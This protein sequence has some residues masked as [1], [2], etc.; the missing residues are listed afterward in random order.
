MDC[1]CDYIGLVSDVGISHDKLDLRI[2]T[3]KVLLDTGKEYIG[4]S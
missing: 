3:N 4:E 1:V 2:P